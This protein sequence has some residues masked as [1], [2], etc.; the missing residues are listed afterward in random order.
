MENKNNNRNDFTYN[1]SEVIGGVLFLILVF[2]GMAI[3][4]KFIN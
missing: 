4:A 1:H 2:A 3:A